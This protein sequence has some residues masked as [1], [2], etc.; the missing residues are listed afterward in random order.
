MFV[1]M[2]SKGSLNKRSRYTTRS[3]SCSTLDVEP[4]Q[5]DN[6]RFIGPLQQAR[7]YELVK[8]KIWSEKIFT[9]NPQGDYRDIMESL[10][11]WRWDTL[12]TP[13]TELNFDLVREFYANTLREEGI[14]YTFC[15][16]VRGRTVSFTRDVIN[17]YL[18]NPHTFQPV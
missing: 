12:L 10:N 3:S 6:T 11:N 14:R 8:R 1:Q 16:F 5:F 18:G 13:P 15:S 4:V 17:Q 7:V 2:S 9:L